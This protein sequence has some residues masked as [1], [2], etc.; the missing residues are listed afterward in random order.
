MANCLSKGQRDR[1]KCLKFRDDGY[2]T[3]DQ[4]E[5]QGYDSCNKWDE[6]CCDWWPCSWAC[7]IIT[8][9]CVAVVWI[10]NWVCVAFVWIANLVCVAWS[11]I[12]YLACT[13][14]D[15]LVTIIGALVVIIESILGWFL[16]VLGWFMEILFSIPFIGRFFKSFWN[17]IL[18]WFWG[19]VSLADSGLYAIGVRPEKKMRICTILLCDE[20]GNEVAKRSEIIA[21]LEK[22]AAVFSQAHVRLVRN[23]PFQFT[24]GFGD[25]ERPSDEWIVRFCPQGGN[26]ASVLDVSCGLTEGS[27]DDLGVTGTQ[28]EFILSTNCFFGN[29]RRVW[30]YGAPVTIFVV[31]EVAGDDAG[32]GSAMWDY[33][34]VQIKPVSTFETGNEPARTIAHE[35]GHACNL[36]H[37]SI[38]GNLMNTDNADRVKDINL[39]MWQQ[40]LIRSSRHVTFL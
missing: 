24:S 40:I 2:E 19:V 17:A 30:G 34:T 23:A 26:N 25:A 37:I 6:N 15:A 31:R 9:V 35:L 28:L 1:Q 20:R 5:D 3:C 29:F 11:A 36:M 21:Q 16:D 39:T 12:T 7:E 4:W 22:A 10:S 18:T 14:I 27:L 13:L 32:C 38:S 8:W 33:V